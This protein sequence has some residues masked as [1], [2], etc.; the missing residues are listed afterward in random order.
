MGQVCSRMK[1]PREELRPRGEE[2]F[3]TLWAPEDVMTDAITLGTLLLYEPTNIFLLKASLH[4]VSVALKEGWLILFVI[5]P[6][7]SG[8]GNERAGT[9]RW[10]DEWL[11]DGQ[12]ERHVLKQIEC[13]GACRL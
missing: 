7:A 10:T 4:W 3:K 13:N 6:V 5:V 12:M 9:G 8:T 2:R 1:S 11:E